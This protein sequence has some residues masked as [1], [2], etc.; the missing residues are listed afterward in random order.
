[1]ETRKKDWTNILFLSLT[2]VVGIFG[3]AAYAFKFGV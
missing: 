1:M 3:T 2:P